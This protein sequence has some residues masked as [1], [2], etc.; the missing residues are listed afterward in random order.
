[1]FIKIKKSNIGN[2][3]LSGG[4][5]KTIGKI[6]NNNSNAIVVSGIITK[7]AKNDNS[8]TLLNKYNC[9]NNNPICILKHIAKLLENFL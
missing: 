2:K 4:I 9:K 5:I 3:N 6:N 8:D 1:M 7:F